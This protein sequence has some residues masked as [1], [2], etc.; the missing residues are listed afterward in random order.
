MPWQQPK[1]DWKLTDSVAYSDMNRIE[2]NIR[3]IGIMRRASGTATAISLSLG[4][5]ING[6]TFKFIAASNNNSAATT[7]NGIPLYN[8][9]TTTSPKII[10]GRAHT[11]WYDANKNCFYYQR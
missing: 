7:I 4:S 1:T 3:N 2:E 11:V 5:L 6:Y 9:G 8:A 10:A